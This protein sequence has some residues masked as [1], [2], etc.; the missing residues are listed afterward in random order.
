MMK[1]EITLK[2]EWSELDRL[3]GWLDKLACGLGLSDHENYMLH[4]ALEEIVTNVMK[5]AYGPGVQKDINVHSQVSDNLLEV[6]VMDHGRPFNPLTADEPVFPSKIEDMKVGGLGIH[7]VKTMVKD[8]RY[9]RREGRNVLTMCITRNQNK[10]RK[11]KE[12]EP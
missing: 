5:Y 7:I 4:L 10:D 2:N 12:R 6:T 11:R 1:Q 8:L 9:E 3:N